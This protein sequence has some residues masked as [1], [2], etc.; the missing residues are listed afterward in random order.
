MQSQLE[1]ALSQIQ[2]KPPI[3]EL[4]FTQHHLDDGNI[5]SRSRLSFTCSDD[6]NR[7][8]ISVSTQERIVK[9]VRDGFVGRFETVCR[10]GRSVDHLIL[11]PIGC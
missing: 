5:G 3:P 4:D 10:D 1:K 7:T 2:D 9:D 11:S 8:H 6:S